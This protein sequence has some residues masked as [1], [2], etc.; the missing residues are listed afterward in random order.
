MAIASI[1]VHTFPASLQNLQNDLQA[2]AEIVAARSVEPDR[3]AAAVETSAAKLPRILQN[4]EK[5]PEVLNLE[6]V[7]VNYEDDLDKSGG[8]ACPPLAD[9]LKQ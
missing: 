8:I 5:M 1:V 3:I 2:L 4:I 9:I 7:F 6:L